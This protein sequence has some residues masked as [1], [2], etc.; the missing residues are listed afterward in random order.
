MLLE[1]LELLDE[2]DEIP[3]ELDELLELDE[4]DELLEL[5]VELELLLLLEE[6]E[7]LDELELPDGPLGSRPDESE[8]GLQA[9][10]EVI[11]IPPSRRRA[12]IKR[13]SITFAAGNPCL[14]Y[15]LLHGFTQHI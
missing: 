14:I 5:E 10:S 9:I 2:P 12:Y 15:L 8:P 3:D 6:L 7:L 11:R 13:R 4:P 1:E